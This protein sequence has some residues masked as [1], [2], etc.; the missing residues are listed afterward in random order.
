MTTTAAVTEDT[1]LTTHR[2]VYITYTH[3]ETGRTYRRGPIA[4]AI[5]E[6]AQAE[7]DARIDHYEAKFTKSEE[8]DA[9]DRFFNGEDMDDLV[10]AG[11]FQ[12]LSRNDV[13]RKCLRRAANR[14]ARVNNNPDRIEELAACATWVNTL[15]NA[16]VAA[17][18]TNA[19]ATWT[20]PEAA[21]F[22]A[23]LLALQSSQN[24]LDH[25]KGEQD[26]DA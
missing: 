2:R 19:N 22:K 8:Q 10:D 3:T 5:G 11:H 24:D 21:A 4:M 26:E 15:T 7:G 18:L 1:N 20:N 12:I 6:N 13:R 25:G 16:T 23:D 9:L 17:R 14:M